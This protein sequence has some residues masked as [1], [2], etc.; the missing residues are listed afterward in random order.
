[1]SVIV[2]IFSVVYTKHALFCEKITFVTLSLN[3][4]NFTCTFENKINKKILCRVGFGLL[5]NLRH[6]HDVTTLQVWVTNAYTASYIS[7]GGTVDNFGLSAYLSPNGTV[8]EDS[9]QLVVEVIHAGRTSVGIP[10]G[11][12]IVLHIKGQ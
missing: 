1:M 10:A 2:V 11:D 3:T 7:D 12:S 5:C 9:A 6:Y 4:K 8:S